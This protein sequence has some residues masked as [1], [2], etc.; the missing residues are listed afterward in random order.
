MNKRMRTKMTLTYLPSLEFS[1][2]RLPFKIE[3][4]KLVQERRTKT[5]V[6]KKD[7]GVEDMQTGTVINFEADYE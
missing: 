6:F 3:D 5:G 1:E 7:G 4:E 2:H